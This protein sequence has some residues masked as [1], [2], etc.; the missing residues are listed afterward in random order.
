M[1]R[2]SRAVVMPGDGTWE[3]REL[4]VPDPPPGGAL[5]RVEAVGMCHS[6]VDHLHGIV[7]TP[8]GGAYPSI[9]GHE[10]VGRIDALADGAGPRWGVTVGQRV[11]VRESVPLPGVPGGI[12]VYG[13]DFAVD[14]RSGLFGGF[15]DYMELLPETLLEPLPDDIPAA[16]LTVWEPLAIA[17]RWATAVKP[18]DSVAILG[19]GH[20]GLASIVA[21]RAAGAKR[22]FITGTPA[23]AIR[24]DAAR[25]LGVEEAIDISTADAVERIRELAGDGVDVVIDAASGSTATVTQGMQMARRGGTVVIG[26]LKDRKPVDG[27]ISDWIPMRQLHLHAGFP[28]DHVKTSVELIRQGKVPTADLLGEVVTMDGFGDALRLLARDLP[29]RDAIR[30]AL[31]LTDDNAA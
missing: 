25:K 13:H 30:L 6:D 21:A 7:H 19:P 23:D 31:T 9:A 15:A 22:I 18:G 24:L 8:W 1:A 16:E 26:G 20:L 10:I 5:L 27:F 17:V 3:L 28:G 29:G 12:R 11:A 2:M 14:E 4:P